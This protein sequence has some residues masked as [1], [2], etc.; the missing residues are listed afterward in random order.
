MFSTIFYDRFSSERKN[1]LDECVTADSSEN[2]KSSTNVKE[3][4]F[5]DNLL[6]GMMIYTPAVH[7]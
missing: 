2:N 5:E 3:K 4:L 1:K 6:E 7:M